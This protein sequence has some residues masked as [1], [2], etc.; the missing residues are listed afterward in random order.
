MGRRGD[1]KS[2]YRDPRAGSI[3]HL[4]L[5]LLRSP[6]GITSRECID[7]GLL[8]NVLRLRCILIYLRDQCGYDYRVIG[9]EPSPVIER[10]YAEGVRLGRGPNYKRYI[11]TCRFSWR[12]D[13]SEDYVAARDRRRL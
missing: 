5:C 6:R 13:V 3:T 1:H 9:T 4:L 2:S 12:G 7:L 10:Q 11:V 8:P